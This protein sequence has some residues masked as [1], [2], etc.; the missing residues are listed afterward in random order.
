MELGIR[1]LLTE[2]SQQHAVNL[3]EIY[4]QNIEE[5]LIANELKNAEKRVVKE[6]EAAE[7]EKLSYE[8][9]IKSL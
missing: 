2:E 5:P 7:N 6:R 4:D 8:A 1:E 9:G 3:P